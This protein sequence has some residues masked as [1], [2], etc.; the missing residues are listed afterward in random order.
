MASASRPERP[1][2]SASHLRAEQARLLQRIESLE[3]HRR[4]LD[5][6]V[7]P[8]GGD[9]MDPV[10]WAHAFLSNDPDDIVARNG[11]TGCY[12][13][14]VNGYIE[15][16]KSGVYLA[17]LTP[18]RKSRAKDAIDLLHESGGVTGQQS[19][20]L[21]VLFVFEGR[22]EH[23]SPDIAAD[24]VREAVELLRGIAGELIA[25]AVRWLGRS[26]VSVI[27]ASAANPP[28]RDGG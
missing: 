1:A 12:S 14:L 9:T 28:A 15:L 13:A 3:A 25:S 10:R 6:A 5:R 8:F 18:H 19:E 7:E 22:V 2:L 16:V 21:H 27:P 24:E 4:G 23:A 26:G 11:L 20:H 17:G